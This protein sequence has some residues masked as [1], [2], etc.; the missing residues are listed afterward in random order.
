MKKYLGVTQKICSKL[1]ASYQPLQHISLNKNTNTFYLITGYTTY[2]ITSTNGTG[3]ECA[4]HRRRCVKLSVK[5][6]LPYHSVHR[7]ELTTMTLHKAEAEL[8]AC[9][10]SI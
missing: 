6:P 4:D 7:G 10:I 5:T 2:K 3:C 9:L 8:G 1:E